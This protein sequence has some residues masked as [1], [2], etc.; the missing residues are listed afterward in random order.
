MEAPLLY[1]LDKN[2]QPMDTLDIS[3]FSETD[4]PIAGIRASM[5]E[6]GRVFITASERQL[7]VPLF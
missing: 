4:I 6:D 2:G 3:F 1:I 5:L 7:G